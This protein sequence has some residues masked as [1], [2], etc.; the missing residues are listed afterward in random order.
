[1]TVN[2]VRQMKNFSGPVLWFT[3]VSFSVSSV[4]ET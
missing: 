2:L 4:T 1:M 3:N